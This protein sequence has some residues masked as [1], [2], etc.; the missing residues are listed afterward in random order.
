MQQ[1]G[2]MGSKKTNA[3]SVLPH[4]HCQ[5]KNTVS[6]FVFRELT[7]YGRKKWC[8]MPMRLALSPSR[9]P[10]LTWKGREHMLHMLEHDAKTV[11]IFEAVWFPKP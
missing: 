10:K 5:G 6:V 8:C 4:A 7:D 11:I 1:M 9:L 2:L 3:N